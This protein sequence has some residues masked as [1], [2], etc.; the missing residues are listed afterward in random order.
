MVDG[1]LDIAKS[2]IDSIRRASAARLLGPYSAEAGVRKE[3]LALAEDAD[4]LVRAG[5]LRSLASADG[6]VRGELREALVRATAD[7]VRLVRL[8]AAFGLRA[9]DLASFGAKDRANVE[10][11]FE[12]LLL[13]PEAMPERPEASYN[14]GVFLASRGDFPG[15]VKAY[16]AALRFEPD[17]IPPR[18]NLAMLHAAVGKLDEAEKE[19]RELLRRNPG[20][21]P[22]AFSLG[23]LYAEQQRWPDSVKA[24]EQCVAEAPGY[25]RARYNLGLALARSGKA[26]QAV[27]ALEKAAEIPGSM[28]DAASALAMIQQQLGNEEESRRWTETAASTPKGR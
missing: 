4:S 24:F 15:A 18:Q 23:L 10:K 21:A 5:A 13:A 8:Q 2:E 25:P 1:L 11:A 27:E 28:R 22:T 17:A 19:F 16:R 12:E 3:L 6:P 20:S 9:M 7:P 26:E 14:T